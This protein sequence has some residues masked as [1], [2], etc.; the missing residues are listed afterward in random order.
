MSSVKQFMDHIPPPFYRQFILFKCTK[1][2]DVSVNRT[3]EKVS[4]KK[5]KKN[6][7]MTTDI[8]TSVQIKII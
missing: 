8:L 1:N 5:V 3:V 4:G 7:D 6:R 2:D